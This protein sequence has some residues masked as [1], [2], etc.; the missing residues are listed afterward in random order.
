MGSPPALA[1]LPEPV[2]RAIGPPG[3]LMRLVEGEPKPEHARPVTPARDDLL[4]IRAFQL[5]MSEDAELVGMRT[6]RLDGEHVDR[7]AER[8][9]RMDHRAI[10]AGRGHLGQRIVDRI[11][12]DLAM[13]RA[14]LAVLPEVD[15]GIDDQHGVLL[16]VELTST[17]RAA[18]T[19]PTAR[20]A[21]RARAGRAGR[22]KSVPRAASRRRPRARWRRRAR[23]W[24]RCSCA[25]SRVSA[26]RRLVTLVVSPTVA[27]AMLR[28]LPMSPATTWP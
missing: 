27:K 15:L 11:R 4:A 1:R 16:A 20:S 2:E 24:P 14:H 6:H 22:G 23:R 26:C 7:L 13:V 5:E 3:L 25:S 21:C 17:L 28:R 10:D 12:R 19:P 18:F 9:G 8:A